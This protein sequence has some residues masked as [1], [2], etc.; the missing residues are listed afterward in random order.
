MPEKVIIIGAGIAGLSTG[1]YLQMN[2]FDTEIHELHNLPGGLCTSWNRNGYTIDGCIHWLV[3]S[4]PGNSLYQS[5]NEL[6]D[7]KKLQ[8]YN[9][10]I[11]Y[12]IEDNQGKS[13]T[14]YNNI[15]K[16]Q[17]ELLAKA[18]EDKVVINDYIKAARKFSR[19]N[20]PMGK[21]YELFTIAD[22][23]DAIIKMGPYIGRLKKWSKVSIMEFASR[24]KNPLL[25]KTMEDLFV[26]EM[27][28]VFA[29]ITT[30]WM[31]NKTAGYPIGG[32]LMFSQLIAK[33]Y[34]DLGGII[35]YKSRI[36][37]ILINETD[38]KK[39]ACG[40]VTG[41]GTE[42]KANYIVSAA[43]GYNTIF[44]LLGG[45]FM[46]KKIEDFYKNEL[47]F[48]SYLQFSIGIDRII[49][50]E[51]SSLIFPLL[52]PV[53]IDPANTITDI[54]IRIHSY[55]PT[56]APAGKTLMESML[57]TR[58]DE[59]WCNLRK[60]DFDKY[61]AEKDRI[62]QEIIEGMEWRLGPLKEHVEMKDLSTPATVKRFT[63]N[64]KGSFEGWI[65]TPK[66]GFSQL[67]MRLPGLNNFYMAGHWV[68]PG[69]GLPSA[70]MT[71]RGVAGLICKKNGK[72]LRTI[73][74]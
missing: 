53:F 31:H 65:M 50:S 14:F 2:G 3:G 42:Y 73:H 32:S 27:G 24:F 66:I 58:E 45:N 59:Y 20:M 74:Y 44:E 28:I 70:L 6:V 57:I 26:P 39:G 5:W 47:T 13:I 68:S 9:H 55:D 41:D 43:D 40:V 4:Q 16:L 8:F 46:D 64:W 22:T 48:S 63:N 69:G 61:N 1:C 19:M 11:Y 72:K 56:L 49:E 67:P 71:G 62:I 10:E 7:M 36:K 25:R 52:K 38:G 30:A 51:S 33:R 37:E 60:N 15:D 17:K 35:H 54:N 34:T 23:L 21:P 12:Q 18:P 29:M